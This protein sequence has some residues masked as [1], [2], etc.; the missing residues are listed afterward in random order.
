MLYINTRSMVRSTDGDIPFF[1]ITTGVLQGYRLT[2]FFIVCL[3]YILKNSINHNTELGFTLIQKISRRNPATYITYIDYADDIDVTTDTL[4]DAKILLYQ[5]E[6]I[7]DDIC[8]K[9]NT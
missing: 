7:E 8:L 6:E 5:I 1:E 3:D 2:T 4:E 9:V